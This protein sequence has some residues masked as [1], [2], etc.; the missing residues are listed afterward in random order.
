[1]LGHDSVAMDSIIKS[2][3]F[4]EQRMNMTGRRCTVL[5]ARW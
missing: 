3:S 4:V 2:V 1:L 5:I